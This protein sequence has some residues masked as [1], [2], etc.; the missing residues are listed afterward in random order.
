MVSEWLHSHLRVSRRPHKPLVG[1]LV[2]VVFRSVPRSSIS[3]SSFHC[4][5]HFSFLSFLFRRVGLRSFRSLKELVGA[6]AYLSER[7]RPMTLD[8]DTPFGEV[9]APRLRKDRSSWRKKIWIEFLFPMGPTSPR[10]PSHP[11]PPIALPSA[12]PG[13]SRRF[14]RAQ[15]GSAVH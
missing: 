6:S 9:S 14:S 7:V 11:P 8:G 1:L 15:H 10:R 12:A 13:M 3:I 2:V 4:L 5:F